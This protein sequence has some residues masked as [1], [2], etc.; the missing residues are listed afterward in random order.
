MKRNKSNLSGALHLFAMAVAM[1]MVFCACGDDDPIEPGQGGNNGGGGGS[2]SQ[3]SQTGDA[4]GVYH[5]QATL[6]GYFNPPKKAYGDISYG[7]I[8]GFSEDVLT[9]RNWD[10]NTYTADTASLADNK[11]S[12]TPLAL[13]AD[14]KYYYRSFAY[15]NSQYYYGE[16]RSFQTSPFTPD[17]VLTGEVSNVLRHSATFDGAF[18]LPEEEQSR[19][20]GGIQLSDS[21]EFREE[22][23]RTCDI[24]GSYIP[25]GGKISMRIR[26]LKPGKT[27]YYRTW[28]QVSRQYGYG[29]VKSFTP[30]AVTQD[31]AVDLDLP[32]GTLWASF[33]IGAEG[34]KQAGDQ[35]R[36]A[37]T[38]GVDGG[39]TGYYKWYDRSQRLYT[40]YWMEGSAT[41]EGIVD[42]LSEI[43][44]EDDAATQNWGEQWQ[45][46]SKEQW[47]E[48]VKECNWTWVS[49]SD[50]EGCRVE[51]KKWPTHYIFLPVTI[52]N[53]GIETKY[54]YAAYWTRT[55]VDGYSHVAYAFSCKDVESQ[56]IGSQYRD[57]DR[58]IRP[59]VKKK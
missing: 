39:R 13:F 55:L 38:V 48:L 20:V 23:T 52:R 32:S 11:Y 47:D 56:F 28:V 41:G 24:D 1:S 4:V 5:V 42:N 44:P 33:N 46:P 31:D 30:K 58:G 6:E 19:A 2:S 3:V 35:F 22:E 12:V 9:Y 57:T 34:E 53:V 25:E 54:D 40:K 16:I 8:V 21:P 45:T 26:G 14:T 18:R 43:Q 37:E 15:V 49:L 29:K 27:C 59:V 51:S 50:M 10:A 17:E 7:I 36:W